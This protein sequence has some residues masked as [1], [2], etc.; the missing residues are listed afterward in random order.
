MFRYGR[1]GRVLRVPFSI[2]GAS[3]LRVREDGMSLD[4]LSRSLARRAISNVAIRV[5]PT[6]HGTKCRVDNLWLSL[7]VDA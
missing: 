1:S 7:A 4:D 5:K 2:V 6:R 3:L